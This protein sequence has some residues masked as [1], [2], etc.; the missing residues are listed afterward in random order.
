MP[1]LFTSPGEARQ[2]A[3]EKALSLSQSVGAGSQLSQLGFMLG[4]GLFGGFDQDPAVQ[5][6]RAV[7]QAMGKLKASGLSYDKDPSGFLSGLG[8]ELWNSGLQ[9]EA[10]EV[11]DKAEEHRKT[12][13]QTQAALARQ[14]V[15]E[16][17][18]NALLSTEARN[19]ELHGSTLKR[20]EAEAQNAVTKAQFGET[21]A[22]LD[23][24]AKQASIQNSMIQAQTALAN[25]Q[26]AREGRVLDVQLKNLDLEKKRLEIEGVKAN[27]ADGGMSQKDI[28]K[29][30]AD[31]AKQAQK[32]DIPTI[33][34]K[35][36][37]LRKLA[38]SGKGYAFN[39]QNY[40]DF[41]RSQ[42]GQ[43][44]A[45]EYN[46]L[47]NAKI[48]ADSGLAVTAQELERT[49]LSMGVHV[50]QNVDAVL[51]GLNIVQS[52]TNAK[53]ENLLRGY[54]TPV[55]EQFERNLPPPPRAGA[56][57]GTPS[58]ATADNDPLG[59]R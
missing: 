3:V 21:R 23:I 22:L 41:L 32:L 6:A 20:A 8:Q 19:Q 31:L 14:Q 16:A 15:A 35:L 38:V 56:P 9:A 52:E 4:R 10:F 57:S 36:N 46:A 48:K 18:T 13:A 5:R 44:F 24:Q 42:A 40:P 26:N 47:I 25:S 50:T 58:A 39:V 55:K 53:W 17:R 43:K 2:A 1:S 45:Q 51:R 54:S 49:K 28:A 37:R 59:I 33:Q 27:M 12:A 34:A 11:I 29:G 30:V 7:E